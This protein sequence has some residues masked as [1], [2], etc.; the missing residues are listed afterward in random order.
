MCSSDINT[1][2]ARKPDFIEGST[3]L[4]LSELPDV[5]HV[6]S[7]AAATHRLCAD[8]TNSGA[9]RWTSPDPYGPVVVRRASGFTIVELMVTLVIVGI[10]AS[11]AFS[12]YQN[13]II[14]ANRSAAEQFMLT[15]ADRQTQYLLDARSYASSIGA[16]GLNLT[17]PATV[18][19]NYTV[20]I[21]LTAGPPPGYL[22]TA[23]PIGRQARDGGLTLDST[24]QKLPVDK[25]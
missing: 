3:G 14:R 25:W 7:I 15:I 18:A 10:I 16:G 17:P 20:T 22:I 4:V 21:A 1:R 8:G 12:T 5:V 6:G 2:D 23:T 19:N 24:G 9:Y 13:Q 11:A